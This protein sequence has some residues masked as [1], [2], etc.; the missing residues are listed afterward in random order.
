MRFSPQTPEA[1]AYAL[2]HDV[3]FAEGVGLG[4]GQTTGAPADSAWILETYLKILKCV[5]VEAPRAG[6][7]SGRSSF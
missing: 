7:I 4:A 3:A 1:V 6:P 5:K 2:L